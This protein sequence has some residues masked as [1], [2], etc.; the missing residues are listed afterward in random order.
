MNAMELHNTGETYQPEDIFDIYD[1]YNAAET[2]GG[3]IKASMFPDD[4][5]T[6]SEVYKIQNS[7][8][9][10]P[11]D[12]NTGGFFIALFKKNAYTYFTGNSNTKEKTPKN[13]PKT[14]ETD[15]QEEKNSETDENKPFLGD[16]VVKDMKNVYVPFPA[17]YSKEWK[18]IEAY[19]GLKDFP[20]DQLYINEKGEKV[21]M[22]VNKAISDFLSLDKKEEINLVNLG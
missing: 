6:M 9:V 17:K 8:R 19:Y 5:K 21:V 3:K 2:R 14:T 18:E 20:G 12:Q 4:I 15:M 16:G 11:H 10:M 22:F 7:M 1:E 13:V